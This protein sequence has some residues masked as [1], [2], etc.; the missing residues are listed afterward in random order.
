MKQDLKNLFIIIL[1]IISFA[2]LYSCN[3]KNIKENKKVE[4]HIDWSPGPDYIGY[5]ISDE[6]GYY[7]E[8]GFDV[9][10]KSGSGAERSARDLKENNIKIGTTTVDAL[11]R[12]ELSSIEKKG[13]VLYSEHSMP[14]IISIIFIKNPVVLITN[15]KYPIKSLDDLDG[16]VVGYTDSLSVTYSQ[17]NSLLK[18]EKNQLSNVKLKRVGWN[19]P[20][21]FQKGTVNGLLAYAT[22]VPPELKTEGVEFNM[23]NLEDLGLTIPGQCIAISPEYDMTPDEIRRFLSATIRGWE[24]ARKNPNLAAKIFISKFPGQ[25]KRKVAMGIEYTID[26][27]PPIIGKGI[28]ASYYSVDMMKLQ[29]ERSIDI[30]A[31]IQGAEISDEI[32]K[33]ISN[34]M[35]ILFADEMEKKQLR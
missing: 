34:N 16:L 3:D 4:F 18:E 25:D 1:V 21:E 17:F 5:F 15:K 23:I 13:E 9:D 8:Q 31:R 19:G 32:V 28:S 22:D 10:I 7:D 11:I 14:K 2:H 33:K 27:L 30:I 24:Y 20:Q 29:I 12:Q 26:L 6:L 35:I